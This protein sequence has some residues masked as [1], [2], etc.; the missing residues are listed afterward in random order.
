MGLVQADGY[1]ISREAYGGSRVTLTCPANHLA[2]LKCKLLLHSQVADRELDIDFVA[3]KLKPDFHEIDLFVIND[4]F[5]VKT[6]V[7]CE[8]ADYEMFTAGAPD[9]LRCLLSIHVDSMA[10]VAFDLIEAFPEGRPHVRRLPKTR[11]SPSA[12]SGG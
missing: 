10:N 11:Y 6:D 7:A 1:S 12:P 9:D 4:E 5:L 8:D 2:P 3:L